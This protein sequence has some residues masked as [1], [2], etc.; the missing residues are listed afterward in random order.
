MR[1]ETLIG[2][3]CAAALFDFLIALSLVVATCL[4]VELY[5]RWQRQVATDWQERD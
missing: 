1:P 3:A 2:R 4:L 5:Q